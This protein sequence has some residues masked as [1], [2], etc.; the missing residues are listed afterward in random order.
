MRQVSYSH[1]YCNISDI[2]DRLLKLRLSTRFHGNLD[3]ERRFMEL[4][5]ETI[6]YHLSVLRENLKYPRLAPNSM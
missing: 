2:E 6:V 4:S 3:Y 5:L 1:Q